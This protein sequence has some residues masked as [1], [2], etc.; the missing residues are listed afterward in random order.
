MTAHFK[1]QLPKGFSDFEGDQAALLRWIVRTLEDLYASWG[2]DLLETPAFEYT[3]C[4]G[5]FLPDVDRP[6]EGVFSLQ[7]EDERWLSLRYDLTAP[8]ARYVAQHYARL[9]KPYRSYRCGYVF[10][11]EKPGPGRLR[12][13]LQCDIDTI[14]TENPAADGEVCLLAATALERL[15]FGEGDYLI[16]LNNRKIMDGLL[17]KAG[18][19]GEDQR[20]RVLRALDKYDRLGMEGVYDLLG[21]GRRDPS[22]DFTKGAELSDLQRAL[23]LDFL[24]TRSLGD[25]RVLLLGNDR[26]LEGIDE[27]DALLAFAAQERVKDLPLRFDPSIVRGLG[28]Y[29][30]PVFEAELLFDTLGEDGTPVRFGAIGGGGRYDGLVSRFQKEPVPATGFSIGVSRLSYALQGPRRPTHLL[31]SPPVVVLVLDPS[32]R[33]RYQAMVQRLREANIR[34]ELYVGTSGLKAQ[35]KYADRRGAALV[36][37]QGE[38]ERAQGMVQIKDLRQGLLASQTVQSRTQ[39]V[40]ERSAQISVLEADL[41]ASVRK[42]L[43]DLG[44]T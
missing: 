18:L 41:V 28:Y 4:L 34:A 16:K 43:E 30:G 9:P 15:G 29:T 10:R 26:A 36:V 19:V 17:E 37:L 3:E 40:Q 35:M 25:A 23:F 39:W 13:F 38:E 20:G 14:G 33:P 6:G 42:S 31:P 22:G 8:L 24:S 27:L 21:A 11:N 32:H 2:F 5:K 7:D 44:E 12:Q 1:A